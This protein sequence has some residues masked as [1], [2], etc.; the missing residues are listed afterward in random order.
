MCACMPEFV[1]EGLSVQMLPR[2]GGPQRTGQSTQPAGDTC[3]RFPARCCR[4][5]LRFCWSCCCTMPPLA[6]CCPSVAV[7]PPGSW[8]ACC[9]RSPCSSHCYCWRVGAQVGGTA[10]TGGR[11]ARQVLA[12][13]RT[14]WLDIPTQ[15]RHRRREDAGANSSPATHLCCRTHLPSSCP[16]LPPLPVFCRDQLLVCTYLLLACH[17]ALD[18]SAQLL[19]APQGGALRAALLRVDH[20]WCIAL[21]ISLQVQFVGQCLM[22]L[23]SL[24][25]KA[26]MAQPG[27]CA[28]WLPSAP[29]HGPSGAALPAAAAAGG[30]CGLL[31]GAA[32]ALLLRVALPCCLAYGTELAARRTF[33]RRV[34][35]AAA[36]ARAAR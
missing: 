33:C 7:G 19:A 20:G 4:S 34:A 29:Q 6:C 27:S 5:T 13:G 35:A 23:A 25:L 22:L 14:M 17:H 16:P 9:R 2:R 24:A 18:L 15:T 21:A 31:D 8:P 11:R 1:V 36:A 30:H 3:S 12:G 28:A 26:A 10:A 32:G